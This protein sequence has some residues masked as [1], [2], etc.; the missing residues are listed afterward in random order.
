[1]LGEH[2]NIKIKYIAVYIAN[3]FVWWARGREKW[4]GWV[5]KRDAVILFSNHPHETP[6]NIFSW[7]FVAII[8]QT[9]AKHIHNYTEKASLREEEEKKQHK[10]AKKYDNVYFYTFFSGGCTIFPS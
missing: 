6:K 2:G 1:M 5:K 7:I 10:T 3:R 4:M 8:F 9:F